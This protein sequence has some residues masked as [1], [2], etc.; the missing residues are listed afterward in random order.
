MSRA[1]TIPKEEFKAHLEKTQALLQ[2]Q[3]LEGLIA[4]SCYAEREGHVCYLTNHHLS[5][6]NVMSHT[7]LGHAAL[8]LPAEGQGI[9]VSPFGYEQEKVVGIAGARTSS[10]LVTDLLLAVRE[11]KLDR[12]K[13]GIAGS[14]VV[15]AEYYQKL[16]RSL[17]KAT[18][19]EANTLLESQRLIKS[20][21]ELALLREA[22]RIADAGLLAGIEAAKEGA[23]GYEIE[24]AARRAALEAGADFIP[25]VRVS[26]GKRLAELRWP[27]VEARRLKPGD[28][29][30]LDLIGWFGNYGFDNSRVTVVGKATAEQR[31]Y[32]AH[33]VEATEWMIGVLKPGVPLEFVYT[34]SR[35]RVIVPF[36]HGIGL[37]ICEN[38][39]IT[40]A[41]KATLQ[42]NMVLCIEPSVDSPVFGSMAIEDTVVVT[43]TGV[44]VLNQCPR[45][46]W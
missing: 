9:L 3:G 31:D 15:P 12:G 29:V 14:D 10:D 36:G 6:P 13:I 34:E 11:Q 1:L 8:V 41:K 7:G 20:E 39:W 30:F 24:L 32:L 5:F 18:F 27:Q 28:L 37:E 17:P 40:M 42:P 38:P 25:R 44:E 4:F 21:A 33:L 2:A 23:W 43:E 26:S 35:E 45:V 22:A 19:Q 16:V 46:L